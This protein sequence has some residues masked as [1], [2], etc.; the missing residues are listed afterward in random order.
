MTERERQRL[1]AIRKRGKCG[2]EV[3]PEERKFCEDMWERYP[4]EY[5]EVEKEMHDWLDS[6]PWWEK[7]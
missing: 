5:K 2:R 1:L 7:L 3:Y 6:A 4:K